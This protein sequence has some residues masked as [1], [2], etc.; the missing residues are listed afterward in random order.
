MENII[1]IKLFLLG[2]IL[3][4]VQLA[5]AGSSGC[6]ASVG[7]D[8]CGIEMYIVPFPYLSPDG[9]R[10]VIRQPGLPPLVP[11]PAPALAPGLAPAAPAQVPPEP[12][13]IIFP[14]GQQQQQQGQEQVQCKKGQKKFIIPKLKSLFRH[15]HGND[16][17][18]PELEDLDFNEH[19]VLCLGDISPGLMNE[20]NDEALHHGAPTGMTTEVCTCGSTVNFPGTTGGA[21]PEVDGTCGNGACS[22][23]GKRTTD[24]YNH[25]YNGATGRTHLAPGCKH[26]I[27]KTVDDHSMKV[28]LGLFAG[29]PI[30]FGLGAALDVPVLEALPLVVIGASVLPIMGEK[31]KS[32][33]EF[34]HYEKAR[35]AKRMRPPKRAHDIEGWK[36]GTK[37][38][39]SRLGVLQANAS[40]FVLTAKASAGIKFV[41]VWKH[42]I[43]KVDENHVRLTIGNRKLAGVRPVGGGWL[44][45]AKAMA[46]YERFW[47][48]DVS[49]T[50]DL[51]HKSAKRAL[52][53][54]LWGML[55]LSYHKAVKK[56]PEED[57]SVRLVRKE[58]NRG[59]KA[60]TP[61]IYARIPLIMKY[62]LRKWR[63]KEYEAN[64]DF[65]DNV[66][67][68]A[69][70]TSIQKSK[71]WRR[72]KSP[73]KPKDWFHFQYKHVTRSQTAQGTAYHTW[74]IDPEVH[75]SITR[76]DAD[77]GYGIRINHH[78]ANTDTTKRSAKK[79]N[80]KLRKRTGKFQETDVIFPKHHDLGYLGIDYTL[81]IGSEAVKHI[82]RQLDEDPNYL[83]N[84]TAEVVKEYLLNEH[85]NSGRHCIHSKKGTLKV[86]CYKRMVRKNQRKM[87]KVSRKLQKAVHKYSGDSKKSIRLAEA[88]RKIMKNPF[89]FRT[90]ARADERIKATYTVQG[91]KFIK[92]SV[93]L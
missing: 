25:F 74:A 83:N 81:S 41:G 77:Q 42:T 70:A 19:E 58:N 26:N 2:L 6:P 20:H 49:F 80:K 13:P 53:E 46:D 4:Q 34:N 57:K 45:F 76:N 59:Q 29:V 93:D 65:E 36:I 85:E 47:S 52:T 55:S 24:I 63:T 66:K 17:N 27:H 14:I 61:R 68:K 43:E 62:D 12:P 48:R 86:G 71:K 88:G 7:V 3:G 21:D 39:Y 72:L 35:H 91:E 18:Q 31:I 23:C 87:K 32:V 33:R 90:F 38:V 84:I 78:Y 5:N 10:K 37:L 69:K 89:L 22:N 30:D 28:G 56:I 75:E 73:L 16:N 82:V 54:A 67:T 15:N 8:I 50:Y 92:Y 64:I 60:Y 51:R 40:L 1:K 9:M 11:P 44:F 79:A